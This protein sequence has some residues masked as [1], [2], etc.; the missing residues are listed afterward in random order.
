M[1]SLISFPHHQ[2][3]VCSALEV[4]LVPDS[5]I[6]LTPLLFALIKLAAGSD[7]CA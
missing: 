1:Y 4:C 2:V 6:R 7:I 5:S 3:L